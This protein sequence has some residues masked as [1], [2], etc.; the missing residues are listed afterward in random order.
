M[1]VDVSL[2]VCP[3]SWLGQLSWLSA[4]HMVDSSLP[5]WVEWVSKMTLPS[6]LSSM[7]NVGS[8]SAVLVRGTVESPVVVSAE[9]FTTRT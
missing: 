8:L 2:L 5:S 1:I 6:L 7:V 3:Q 4:L 9:Y